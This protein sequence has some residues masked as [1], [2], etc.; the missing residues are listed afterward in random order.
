MTGDWIRQNLTGK[1]IPNVATVK[2]LVE[3]AAQLA[4]LNN[5]LLDILNFLVRREVNAKLGTR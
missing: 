5:T 1:S 2:A 4:E 3:I